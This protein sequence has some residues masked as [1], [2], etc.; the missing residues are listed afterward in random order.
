LDGCRPAAVVQ[1]G[2]SSLGPAS[3]RRPPRDDQTGSSS[4]PDRRGLGLDEPLPQR[5]AKR[6]GRGLLPP[7]AGEGKDG[8]ER[9]LC[10]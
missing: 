4:R 2:S 3:S 7:W 6:R 10:C 9:G 1:T 8:D 5:V